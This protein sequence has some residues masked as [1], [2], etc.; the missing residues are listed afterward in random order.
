M[1]APRTSTPA[2]TVCRIVASFALLSTLLAC[3]YKGPLY[4]PPPPAPDVELTTPPEP[5][6]LPAETSDQSGQPATTSPVQTK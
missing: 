6:N 5:A 1:Q 3:G 4:M 2:R